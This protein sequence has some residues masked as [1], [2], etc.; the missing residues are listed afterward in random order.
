VTV[1]VAPSRFAGYTALIFITK[2]SAVSE[3]FNVSLAEYTIQ[4]SIGWVSRNPAACGVVVL[5]G[6]VL[7]LWGRSR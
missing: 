4:A 3:I 5:A 2:G 7:V 6:L 1:F